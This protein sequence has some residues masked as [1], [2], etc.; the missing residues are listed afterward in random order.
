[1]RR[2]GILIVMTVAIAFGTSARAWAAVPG[3]NIS[4]GSTLTPGGRPGVLIQNF[5]GNGDDAVFGAFR[6]FSQSAINLGGPPAILISGRMPAQVVVTGGRL[7]GATSRSGTAKGEGTATSTFD[8][9]IT[10]ETGVVAAATGDTAIAG[11]SATTET[12]TG[13]SAGSVSVPEPGAIALLLLAG[14]VYLQRRR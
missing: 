3:G 6:G 8:D 9:M 4:E 11:T 10:S 5:T 1:M 12:I 13:T 14:V 2:A 7:F